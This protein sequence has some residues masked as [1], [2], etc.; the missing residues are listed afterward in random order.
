M[1]TT[2][3]PFPVYIPVQITAITQSH[4][5]VKSRWGNDQEREYGWLAGMSHATSHP[6]PSFSH[7]TSSDYQNV[8][9]PAED[10]FLLMDALEKESNF[11]KSMR[12]ALHTHSL[13]LP[14][15]NTPS[16]IFLANRPLICAEI[17]SGSGAVVTFLATL[18][19]TPSFYWHVHILID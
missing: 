15:S 14:P 4:S 11:L 17:G 16:S 7:L 8:Y 10:S 1:H 3:R 6:T 19:Q 9:E 2:W 5:Q 18:L 13:S 12:F